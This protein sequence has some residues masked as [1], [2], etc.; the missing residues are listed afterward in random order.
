VRSRSDLESRLYGWDEE[1]ESN[2]VE[3][4]IHHLRAKVGRRSIETL[5]GIGY[6]MRLE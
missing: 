1:V 6:R 2:A 4:H 5:R 3:V